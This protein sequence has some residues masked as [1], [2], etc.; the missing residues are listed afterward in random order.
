MSPPEAYTSR[1]KIAA[2]LA[3]VVQGKENADTV[4]CEFSHYLTG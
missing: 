4:N 2:G 1:M 3:A